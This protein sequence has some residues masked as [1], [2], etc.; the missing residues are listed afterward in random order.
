[1]DKCIGHQYFSGYK[2]LQTNNQ[3]KYKKDIDL[4]I[5]V[6]ETSKFLLTYSMHKHNNNVIESGNY[7]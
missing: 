1:M 4:W 3:T 6:V 2:T 7:F 5:I